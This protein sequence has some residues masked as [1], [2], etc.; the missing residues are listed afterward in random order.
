MLM[1][2]FGKP[3]LAI[4]DFWLN[5]NYITFGQ[6]MLS[7]QLSSEMEFLLGCAYLKNKL[8]VKIADLLQSAQKTLKGKA[9]AQ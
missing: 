6:N 7:D 3:Y 5:F 4:F 8:F 2:V 9:I 1:A